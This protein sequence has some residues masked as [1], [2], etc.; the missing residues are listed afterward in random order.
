MQIKISDSQ[1]TLYWG[2]MPLPEG[3]KCLGVVTNPGTSTGALIQLANGNYVQGNAGGIRCQLN[4]AE[5]E[6]ALKRR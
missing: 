6:A 5:V 3:A 4:K 2:S 1:G